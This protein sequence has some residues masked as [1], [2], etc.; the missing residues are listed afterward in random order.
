MTIT[1]T[2]FEI[3]TGIVGLSLILTSFLF[4]I[5]LLTKT[6]GRLKKMVIYFLIGTIPGA[7]YLIGRLFNFETLLPEGKLINLILAVIISFFVLM[8][9][10]EL[11]KIVNELIKNKKECKT[12]TKE[13]REIKSRDNNQEEKT[14]GKRFAE[15]ISNKYLDLTG[16]KPRYREE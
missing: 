15:N 1:L 8:G 13:K 5:Q 14:L 10:I 16:R 4:C 7:L 9:L 3:A 11:N 2:Y 6:T 12:G